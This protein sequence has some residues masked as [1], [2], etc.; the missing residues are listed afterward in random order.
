MREKRKTSSHSGISALGTTK[1]AMKALNTYSAVDLFNLPLTEFSQPIIDCRTTRAHDAKDRIPTSVPFHEFESIESF[2]ARIDSLGFENRM[3]VILYG[4]DSFV[5][6]DSEVL[7]VAE[8]LISHNRRVSVLLGG[9][10][11][12]INQFPLVPS[13][14]FPSSLVSLLNF[15]SPIYKSLHGFV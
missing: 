14:S 10:G 13:T 6:R 9:Y 2:L 12:F 4:A 3:S 7:K 11:A 8:E 5:D 1:A 15:K